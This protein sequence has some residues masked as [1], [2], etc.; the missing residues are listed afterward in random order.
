MPRSE[1]L[2]RWTLVGIVAA[3]A[4]ANI[5]YRLLHVGRLEQTAALFIGLPSFL[6]ALL[7]LTVRPR[8]PTG[9]ILAGMTFAMLLSGPLLQEGFICIVMAAP[10]FYLVGWL[11]GTI[12]EWTARRRR[13]NRPDDPDVPT[14]IYGLVLIPFLVLSLEGV[15]PALSFPRNETVTVQ[16]VL[17]VAPA[18]VE[19]A[20]SSPP[21]FDRPLP[22]YLAMGFPRPT[23]A[24]GSGLDV[25]D[26]R[27]V[28]FGAG[29]AELA[30]VVADRRATS[31]RFDAVSDSSRISQW[32]GWQNAVVEWRAVDE[33]ATEVRW[34]LRYE[35][36]LDPAWYF[37]PWERYAVGLT[38][39]YL[40][41]AV[42]N[43]MD[44]LSR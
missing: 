12:I 39:E 4:L 22:P 17:P 14:A 40:I 33:N 15:H 32:L 38:A 36:R 8:T 31:V 30:M 24:E 6:A 2:S 37:A 16:R 20:L 26:R 18:E 10:L 1:W 44:G 13:R 35:R 43:P 21:R 42:A 41:D 9:I 11:L 25:G 5:A 3:L 7:A 29:R 23:R 34:T 28:R 19:A 27:A